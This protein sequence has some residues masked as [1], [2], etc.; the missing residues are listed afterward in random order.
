MATEQLSELLDKPLDE[1]NIVQLRQNVLD[2]TVY[3]KH[4]RE[5]LLDDTLNGLQDGRWSFF[6][7]LE[8]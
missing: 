6:I 3:V 8:S 4:R 7:D 5:V 1:E 2:K